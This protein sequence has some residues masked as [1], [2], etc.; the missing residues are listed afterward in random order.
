MWRRSLLTFIL[1]GKRSIWWS[2][3][4]TLVA[5]RIVN[6]ISFMMQ[7][8]VW[9]SWQ[10]QYLVKLEA[11]C[12]CSAHSKWRY[13]RDADQSWDSFC[14]AG[15]KLVKLPGDSCCSACWKFR[16]I[17]DAEQ[18]WEWLFVPSAVFGEVGGWFF[19][20]SARCKYPFRCDEDQSWE[21]FCMAGAV[22]GEVGGW[23]LVL[24]AV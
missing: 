17:R 12:C 10:G 21:S 20:C 14:V 24:R 11:D 16:F 7:I 15:T 9:L 23:L 4:L 19:C 2:W 1:R 18:S 8:E 6:D 13:I 22:F 5:P 3:G